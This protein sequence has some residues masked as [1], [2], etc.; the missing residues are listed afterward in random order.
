MII[1]NDALLAFTFLTRIP[2]PIP[3]N[4]Y[5]KTNFARSFPYFP[6][7]GI[8]LGALCTAG[9]VILSK[10]F[11]AEISSFLVVTFLLWITRGLHMD[12]LAD[13]A[14][15]LGGGYTRE[16]RLEILKDSRIGS[17]GAM[18]LSIALLGKTLAISLL[19]KRQSWFSIFCAPLF[20]RSVM[21]ALALGME[22]ARPEADHGLGNLFLSGFSK[23]HFFL[24]LIWW[25]PFVAYNPVM[26]LL[27]ASVIFPVVMGLRWNFRKCFGGLTGDL[28]GAAC[29]V[30]EL[31]ALITGTFSG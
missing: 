8:F 4:L 3:G 24:S 31:T 28:F 17:F 10:L 27:T 2:L 9:G 20:G 6:A 7:V 5:Q 13:W 12:G 11:P 18:A 25:V 1:L 14:D 21:V 29:E 23:K 15:A 26:V 30:V 16:K 22:P 19:I